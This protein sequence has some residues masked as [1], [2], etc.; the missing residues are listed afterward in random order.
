MKEI[1]TNKKFISVYL[2]WGLIHTTLLLIGKGEEAYKTFWPFSIE[3]Y[4]ESYDKSEWFFYMGLP[5]IL[6]MLINAF[7]DGSNTE[8]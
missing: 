5:I 1:I 4:T 3:D 7:K 8:L 6:V 2:V